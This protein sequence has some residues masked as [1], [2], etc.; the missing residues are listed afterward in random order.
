[1]STDAQR[2]AFRLTIEYDGTRYAGWQRQTNAPTVQ[3]TIEETLEK[4]IRHP[5]RCDGSGRTD[6]GV[7]A[8]GQ[9][10]RI[11]VDNPAIDS[12][13]IRRGGNTYLPDDI[14]ILAAK[15]CPLEFDPRRDARLR[16]YRYSILTRPTA[17]ALGRHT[18]LHESR[19]IDWTA[20]EEGLDRLRG[21]HDFSAFR[22]AHCRAT[23]T[24]LFLQ[25]ALHTDEHP[26]HHFD[27][28]CRSYL[29]N[30]IR[31][32][33]GI[34]IEVGVGKH[35]PRIITEMLEK[36]ERTISF[37]CAPPQGLILT[38]VDYKISKESE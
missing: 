35:P 4:I 3:Q 23:R 32:M 36:K 24:Q 17:S 28:E 26:I 18:L 19:P 1:M 25:T 31:L 2:R 10:A 21:D 27:F 16:H 8:T 37:R 9:V 34:L 12:E 5:I 7:H 15:L 6:A 38:R 14:R 13:S 22:S 30:M 11:L 20:V 33:S 29:H